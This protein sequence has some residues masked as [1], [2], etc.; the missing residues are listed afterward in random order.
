MGKK[1]TVLLASGGVYTADSPIRDRDIAAQYLRLILGVIGVD[2]VESIAAGNAKAVDLGV[3]ARDDF[4]ARFQTEIEARAA[5]GRMP[6]RRGPVAGS[7]FIASV[8]TVR[9]RAA[10]RARPRASQRRQRAQA[11][12]ARVSIACG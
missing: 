1:A 2:D 10:I 9:P 3:V 6:V 12:K 4:L 8:R 5:I 7:G 11:A